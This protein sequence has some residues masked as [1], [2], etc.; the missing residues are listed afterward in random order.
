MSTVIDSPV[1]PLSIHVR[2]GRLDCIEICERTTPLT[3]PADELSRRVA[4]QIQAYFDDPDRP[5]DLPIA[6]HL[7]P[8][9]RRVRAALLAIPPGQVRSYGDLARELDSSPR[10]VGGACRNNPLPLVVPCHRVVASQ[11]IGGFSGARTGRWLEIK[12]W[13]LEHEGAY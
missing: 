5:F 4:E 8:F 10:A 2:A 13:L 3:P 9:Q 6:D 7:T 11:G 1:G 12:R